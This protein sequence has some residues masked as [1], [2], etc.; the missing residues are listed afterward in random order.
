MRVER[1][2]ITVMEV[3]N[4]FILNIGGHVHNVSDSV[5]LKDFQVSSVLFSRNVEGL[6]DAR[7]R[8]DDPCRFRDGVFGFDGRVDLALCL[9]GS[10]E[11]R[12]HG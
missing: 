12:K 9:A 7:N 5:R 4:E 3:V 6:I 10:A 2:E 1:R 11:V 8:V